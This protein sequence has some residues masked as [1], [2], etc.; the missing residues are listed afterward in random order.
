VRI[1][2]GEGDDQADHEHGEHASEKQ[3]REHAKRLARRGFRE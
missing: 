1:I 3:P 2:C